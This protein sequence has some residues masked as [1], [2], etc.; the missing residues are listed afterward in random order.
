MRVKARYFS[1][2]RDIFRVCEWH[3]SAR[4]KRKNM[5]KEVQIYVERGTEARS[6]GEENSSG[7]KFPCVEFGASRLVVSLSASIASTRTF[8]ALS[9]DFSST[10][11]SLGDRKRKNEIS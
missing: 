5:E 6:K 2:N 8:Y 9:S 10:V 7:W 4:R 3:R 11:Y 1:T